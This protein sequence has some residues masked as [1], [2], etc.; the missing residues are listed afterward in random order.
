MRPPKPTPKPPPWKI[1]KPDKYG[2]Y[3]YINPGDVLPSLGLYKPMT[4]EFMEFG[5]LEAKLVKDLNGIWSGPL[6][7]PVVPTRL[8]RVYTGKLRK[9][10]SARCPDCGKPIAVG[11]AM[12]WQH[13]RWHQRVEEAKKWKKTRDDIERFGRN[14]E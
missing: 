2:Y 7:F 11:G 1:E 8:G 9:Y 4:K 6:R 10:E 3:W 12:Q 14:N 5:A 13:R